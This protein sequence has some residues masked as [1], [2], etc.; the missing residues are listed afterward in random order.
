MGLSFLIGM[1]GGGPYEVVELLF[2]L[3]VP[4]GRVHVLLERDCDR[5]PVG[6]LDAERSHGMRDAE[7][8]VGSPGWRIVR[9]AA[10]AGAKDAELAP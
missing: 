7:L 5:R 3:G 2:D 4:Q 6:M 9:L 10:A 1:M 8:L